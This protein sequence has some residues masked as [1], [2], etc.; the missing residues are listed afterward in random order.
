MKQNLTKFIITL[1]FILTIVLFLIRI[2]FPTSQQV[3]TCSFFALDTNIT[4]NVYNKVDDIEKI[5]DDIKNI[6]EYFENKLSKTVVDSDLYNINNKNDGDYI[7]ISL[8]T[9]FL[10]A[11]SKEMYNFS[12]EKFDISVG[13]L[14]DYWTKVRLDEIKPDDNKIKDLVKTS[15]NMDYELCYND[16][17]LK[18][19]DEIYSKIINED[20]NDYILHI[21]SLK[22]KDYKYFIKLKNNNQSY[23]LGAIAKGYIADYVKYYLSKNGVRSAVINLG[24]NVLCIGDKLGKDFVIGIKKPFYENEIIDRV[25]I[26]DESVT[27]SGVYERYIKFDGDDTIYHHIVDNMTGYP[28]NNELLSATIITQ[29]SVFG[30]CIST[31]CILNGIEDLRETINRIKQNYNIDCEVIVVDDKYSIIRV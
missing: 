19:F 16:G 5:F 11:L 23:D 4:I 20:I 28:T 25:E 18:T 6:I 9:A 2:K 21:D 10:F 24:G 12:N 17:K 31:I 15:K 8:D 3:E 29:L 27:T 14:V 1:V 22:Q 7:D 26:S 13:E 30:D